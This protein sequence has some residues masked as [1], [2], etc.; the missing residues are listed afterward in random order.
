[1]AGIR[2]FAKIFAFVVCV[3]VANLAAAAHAEPVERGA[4]YLSHPKNMR[5]HLLWSGAGVAVGLLFVR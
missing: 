5:L 2:I 3:V 1:M 4:H